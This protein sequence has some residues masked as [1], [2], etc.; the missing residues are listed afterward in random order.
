M[1]DDR[2]HDG[3]PPSAAD[4]PSRFA[5]RRYAFS[6]LAISVLAVWKAYEA[7]IA[8]TMRAAISPSLYIMGLAGF[9]VP[10]RH[11]ELVEVG[12]E[13]RGH[14][15]LGRRSLFLHVARRRAHILDRG[16]VHLI[17]RR[18]PVAL[19]QIIRP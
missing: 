18:I 16:G 8:D 13:R 7:I 10:S 9:E 3:A 5:S 19:G 15:F 11:G 14:L 17:E 1:S 2:D 4:D 6:L 12:E